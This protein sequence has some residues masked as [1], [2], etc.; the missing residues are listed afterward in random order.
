MS[1]VAAAVRA[2]RVMH[3]P[4]RRP[5]PPGPSLPLGRDPDG[6][7][8]WQA[9]RAQWRL[10][11]MRPDDYRAVCAALYDAVPPNRQ[12]LRRSVAAGRP[13][14]A[15]L[16]LVADLAAHDPE[17]AA[18]RLRLV[19][20]E[21]GPQRRFGV[22]IDQV[23]ATT[24]GSAVLLVLATWADPLATLALTTPEFN[25]L[26]FEYRLD[27]RQLTIHRQ[28][29]RLWPRAL[30]T[31]PWGMVGWLRRHAAGLGPYRVR[32][33][34]ADS[35][36][37]IAAAVAEVNAALDLADL[38]P[39]L[40]GAAVPRH[41]ALALSRRGGEW[42]VYDPGSGEVR[43]VPVEAVR[44]REL[45]PLLGFDRLQAVLLPLRGS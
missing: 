4:R 30:G 43:V 25:V 10:D 45:A 3:R 23:D 9:E 29:N 38:V 40:V 18:Q 13:A 33:V 8:R 36:A 11:A 32:L 2:G 42:R 12:Y 17:W 16:S 37:D 39:L 21:P 6:L 20:D 24:C 15:V 7:T 26:G 1:L 34:D 22:L 44:Q 14:A 31:S 19:D 5:R 28:S 35:T 41:Y 27:R